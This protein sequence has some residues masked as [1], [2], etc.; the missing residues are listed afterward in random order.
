[1][2]RHRPDRRGIKIHR[3]YTVEEVARSLGIA[4]G[5]VRRWIK[6]GLPALN[7]RKPML[8]LGAD[9][10]DFLRTR[11]APKQ[12]CQF[13]ECYCVKCR[14]PRAAAEAMADF[15]PLTPTT[16]NLRAL[17]P[18]CTTLMHKRIALDQLPAIR[19]VLEVTTVEARERIIDS[20]H[21]SLNDHIVTEPQDH[22]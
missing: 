19:A 17:C 8:I 6:S 12:R 14:A 13:H 16:G 1:M 9:L 20:R 5:S 18:I 7:E 11:A 15:V 3:S 4:K 21:P 10:V 22:A 2:A